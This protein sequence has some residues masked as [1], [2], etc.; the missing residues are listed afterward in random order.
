[1]N[2][3]ALV[4]TFAGFPDRL[5]A[6]ALA[7]ADRPVATGEW[8]HAEVVRHLLAVENE[9]WKPR[10]ASVAAEDD[11]LWRWTE[12]GLAP[13]FEGLPLDAIIAAF[14]IARATTAATVRSLDEAGWAR[15]GTHATYG[16]LDVEGLLGMAIDHDTNHLEGLGAGE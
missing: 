4:A 10:L 5:A 8:G 15:F 6:P 2:R 11:P 1:V 14:A 9:V 12:P 7:V 16:R 3:E 13:G